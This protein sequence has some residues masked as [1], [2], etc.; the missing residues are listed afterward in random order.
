MS[1]QLAV[2]LMSGLFV[3]IIGIGG[4]ISMQIYALNSSVAELRAT[5]PYI[6]ARTDENR[7]RNSLLEGRILQ[8]ERAARFT[9]TPSRPNS[10]GRP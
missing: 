1:R 10:E 4:F 5:L 3:I 6:T 9:V 2:A 7:R 8:L